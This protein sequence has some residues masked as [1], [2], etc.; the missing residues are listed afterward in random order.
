MKQDCLKPDKL[1][2]EHR[3]NNFLHIHKKLISDLDM[4]TIFDLKINFYG[5]LNSLFSFQKCL[6]MIPAIRTELY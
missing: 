3:L 1:H 5:T 2:V 6:R 4:A